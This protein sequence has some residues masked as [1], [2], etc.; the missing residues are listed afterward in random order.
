MSRYIAYVGSYTDM[1]D[2]KG[3][4]VLSL[5]AEDG[6]ATKQSEYTVSNAS[7][8]A[9]SHDHR[10]LYAITDLGVVAFAIQEDG[11]LKR[12]NSVQIKGMRGCHITV[13]RKNTYL[14]VCGFYDGKVTV[15]R[16]NEDGTLGKI[17][18]QRYH[19]S[20]GNVTERN[21][22]PHCRCSCFSPDE[23]YLFVADSGLDQVRIYKFDH[24][25]GKLDGLD[26]LH[27]KL[28][29]APCYIRFSPDGKYFYVLKEQLNQITVYSYED[30][31]RGPVLNLVEIQS[32]LA[33]KF[34]DYSAAVSF[35][36]TKDGKNLIVC[37]SGENSICIF[38]RD[39]E[40]G[41]L[42]QLKVLP[43]S[44]VYPKNVGVFPDGKH[45][46]SV[47]QESNTLSF[48]KVDMETGQ[49]LMQHKAMKIPQPSCAFILELPEQ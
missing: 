4:T 10:Y 13:S 32:T 2:G 33:K 19:R 46:F 9:A 39:I 14:V 45:L 22:R 5:N 21:L 6:S 40:T 48:F 29:A 34:N 36:I 31:R 41:K 11:D 49:I 28:K 18:D 42:T 15:L 43:I 12:L 17:A 27:S 37:N 16:L 38:R 25:A 1:N 44:G 30:S 23:K 26:I 24:D 47:N 8:V 3:L 7:Y 20:P 35:V